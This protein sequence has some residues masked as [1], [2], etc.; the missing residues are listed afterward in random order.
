[1]MKSNRNI[2]KKPKTDFYLT[3]G[4]R[5]LSSKIIIFTLPSGITCRGAGECAKWCYS[6]KAEKSYPNCLKARMRN[7]EA[8]KRTDFEKKMIEALRWE[9]SKG[10]NIL[11]LHEDGDAY[12]QEY[13]NKWKRIAKFLPDLTIFAFTK[14]HDLDLWTDL[15]NNFILIQSLGSRF[16]DKVDW[17]RN[18]ARVIDKITEMRIVEYLCPYHDKEHFTKCGECC[19]YCMRRD[20]KVKH[21][22]FLKH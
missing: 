15:P 10:R 18:T 8:S 13:L 22:S 17:F 4:N 9:M 21:V 19:D 14:S 12:N 20:G 7:F 11:R 5:K 1:M 16:D 2:R 6:K 3:H